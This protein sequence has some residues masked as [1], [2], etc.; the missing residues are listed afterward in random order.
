M[1]HPLEIP[2][3]INSTF[4]HIMHN[5]T[6]K[7]I[8]TGCCGGTDKG[9]NAFKSLRLIHGEWVQQADALKIVT[10]SGSP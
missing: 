3:S 7:L 5:K 6:V 9:T 4:F 1:N 10:S 8:T 2:F